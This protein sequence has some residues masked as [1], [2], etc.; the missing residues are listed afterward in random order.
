MR[1]VLCPSYRKCLNLAA[2]R[3]RDFDCGRCRLRR[4]QPPDFERRF[5]LWHDLDGCRL[6]LAALFF[7]DLYSAYNELK[8]RREN[9]AGA[10]LA[11]R[12]ELGAKDHTGQ[13]E[14][15]QPCAS[16]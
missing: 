14:I 16:P 2:R 9:P 7:P 3:N 11:G 4:T 5:F 6:L 13:S 1:N 12:P 15:V 8:T 10:A